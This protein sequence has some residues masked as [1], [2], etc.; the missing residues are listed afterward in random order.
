MYK[1]TFVIITDSKTISTTT[2]STS[3]HAVPP[4]QK[5]TTTIKNIL[6]ILLQ[7]LKEQSNDKISTLLRDWVNDFPKEFLQD[8]KLKELQP[9]LENSNFSVIDKQESK[10]IPSLFIKL[11]SIQLNKKIQINKAQKISKKHNL[12]RILTDSFN[13]D[14]NV[15]YRLDHTEENI[16]EAQTYSNLAHQNYIRHQSKKLFSLNSE[17]NFD[18][19]KSILKIKSN[20]QFLKKAEASF[21]GS[22]LAMTSD[23]EKLNSSIFYYLD[24]L[25]SIRYKNR[26]CKKVDSVSNNF[27]VNEKLMKYCNL[28]N[29]IL[30]RNSRISSFF[31]RVSN[32]YWEYLK[33]IGKV[34]TNRLHLLLNKRGK[35][36]PQQKTPAI[37]TNTTLQ[38]K[39]LNPKMHSIINY[40]PEFSH[41][42]RKPLRPPGG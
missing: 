11:N 2:L 5:P 3:A 16:L 7:K 10:I 18:I 14:K 32:K 22:I 37:V 29:L 13:P 42:T 30:C 4:L 19:D 1:I 28:V 34:D 24:K 40:L 26:Q 41:T 9:S 39:I 20:Y 8:L 21:F 17:T 27:Q 15:F 6:E 12:N 23:I 35:E 36:I 31:S 38:Y 25:E 33:I